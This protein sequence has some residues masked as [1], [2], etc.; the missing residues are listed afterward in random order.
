MSDI[1][2]DDDGFLVGDGEQTDAESVLMREIKTDTTTI[3]N[4]LKGTAKLQR[5][6]LKAAQSAANPKPK[7]NAGGQAQ[8]AGSSSSRVSLNHPNRPSQ[9]PNNTQGAPLPPTVR[10]NRS[11]AANGGSPNAEPNNSGQPA[12]NGQGAGNPSPNR[13]GTDRVNRRRG[14][15]GRFSGEGGASD[16]DSSDVAGDGSQGRGNRDSRG[17]FTG[18]GDGSSAA[19]RSA[20]SK[21]TD[22][23]KDL[24]NNLTLNAN[25]EHIDPMIDAIKEAGDVV[26]AGVDAS[27][28]ALSIGNTLVAKPVMALGRGIKGLFKPKTD[29]INSPVAWYKRIWKTL[30]LGNR[31]D[32]ADHNAEQRR[33]DELAR[34]QNQGGGGSGGMLM[35]LGLALL[36]GLAALRGLI[37]D[38]SKI[39]DDAK[40]KIAGLGT[41][42]ESPLTKAK[43]PIKSP[44]TPSRTNL[45][46]P[47]RPPIATDPTRTQKALKWLGETKVGKA[48][49]FVA[50]GIPFLAPTLEAGAGGINGYN[51]ENDTTLTSEQK[52]QKQAE[53]AAR[54]AGR[55]SG[56]WAGAG[57]GALLGAKIGAPTG[58]PF[59]IGV[60][61][62]AGS[63]IGGIIGADALGYIGEKAGGALNER[64]IK[65]PKQRIKKP[66]IEPNIYSEADS[67]ARKTYDAHKDLD[68]DGNGRITRD[69]I[70]KG[71]QTQLLGSDSRSENQQMMMYKAFQN[72]DFSD[73]QAKA[74]TAEVGRENSYSQKYMYGSHIDPKNKKTNTG[75]FSWQGDRRAKLIEYMNS[76]GLVQDDG[77]FVQGQ[78]S[79][80]AQARFAKYEM[81]KNKAYSKTKDTFLANPNINQ[82]SAARIL[83]EDY[84]GWAIN[85]PKY[86]SEGQSR[87]R[88]HLSSLEK[89]LGVSPKT[90]TPKSQPLPTSTQATSAV[91]SIKAAPVAAIKAPNVQAVQ[92]VQAKEQPQ[93][94]SSTPQSVKVTMPKSLAGQNVSDRGIAHILTGGIG[95]S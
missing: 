44:V 34:G 87:R 86:S 46:H 71:K 66:F 85:N 89:Q 77:S 56:G 14:A 70:I 15:N 43:L 62:I 92:S 67:E 53:N 78:E 54:T 48:A 13:Q 80:D 27:K 49:K 60:T 40:K 32:H 2:I 91:P 37:P 22:G 30:T 81:V 75:I 93:R 21:I 79:L 4:L 90:A 9:S 63:I 16:V 65:T 23:L 84:V 51:I 64:A 88:L 69:E 24:S 41:D 12:P 26:S 61:T 8:G 38:F 31:Q 35:M 36:A 25:T 47:N 82:E 58:N 57:T 76:K 28:K 7:G 20:A 29:A 3:V 10:P 33:L 50:K 55:I 72:A 5:D 1:R 19:E 73:N 94:L 74:L 17:R 6:A 83:G 45:N 68:V 39:F 95:E 59:V 11:G 18:G 42:N 52:Q